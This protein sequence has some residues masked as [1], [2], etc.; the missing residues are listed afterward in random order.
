MSI[1]RQGDTSLLPLTDDPIAVWGS[2]KAAN[3]ANIF[4][5][6]L[7]RYVTIEGLNPEATD[8]DI[9]HAFKR[10]SI[11]NSNTLLSVLMGRIACLYKWV[12]QE[13]PYPAFKVYTCCHICSISAGQIKAMLKRELNFKQLHKLPD[14][15]NDKE[16]QEYW[17]NEL[18]TWSTI[19]FTDGDNRPNIEL[20]DLKEGLV[21]R[22]VNMP[23]IYAEPDLVA[24]VKEND[25]TFLAI[26]KLVV[27]SNQK[28]FC[29]TLSKYEIEVQVALDCFGIGTAYLVT[30]LHDTKDLSKAKE[31]KIQKIQRSYK[32]ITDSCLLLRSYSSFVV[33]VI[34]ELTGNS[35]S[36]ESAILKLLQLTN[37]NQILEFTGMESLLKRP[38]S[39]PDGKCE[40]ELLMQNITENKKGRLMKNS[41]SGIKQTNDTRVI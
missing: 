33:N 38:V 37:I 31:L 23:W 10:L 28:L 3:I 11:L 13:G 26:I 25:E 2:F 7:R 20:V 18:L 34:T 4:R 22:S 15:N 8:K 12:Y 40:Y 29:D 19:Q 9:R 35:L 39:L 17:K 5:A 30:I 36:Q 21:H 1:N 24:T 27:T 41:N 14:D 6:S 32:L 16:A